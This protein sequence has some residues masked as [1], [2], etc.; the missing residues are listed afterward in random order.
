[1]SEESNDD[2]KWNSD[3]EFAKKANQYE[4][5][6]DYDFAIRA[7]IEVNRPLLIRGEPGIG[8]SS[9]A[10]AA[11]VKLGRYFI[12]EV[13]TAKTEPNDL[14]WQFDGVMRLGEATAICNMDRK[15]VAT[16][17]NRKN[18]TSPG[19]FWWAF[20]A[21]D[22]FKRYQQCSIGACPVTECRTA[23]EAQKENPGK[24]I[25]WVVLIDE[26]DKADSDIPN[27]LLGT[28][29][30][31]EFMVPGF[32]Q[33]ICQDATI[34]PPLIIITTNEDREL[35]PAFLRRCFVLHM[36]FPQD[37][38]QAIPWLKKCAQSHI[39]TAVSDD[40][41]EIMARMV[42]RARSDAQGCHKPGLAE[43][44]DLVC[45]YEKML[46]LEQKKPNGMDGDAILKRLESFTLDKNAHR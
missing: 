43:Y 37:E 42:L 4:W 29:A 24:K 20:Q 41:M 38:G 12:S 17:L 25:G 44:I 33:P 1:M 26:I 11:A 19:V 31:Q 39:K 30:N 2:F 21:D 6:D 22:A 5:D 23:I 7:A 13:I 40:D 15:D 10:R 46:A 27:S 35:P 8:K 32:E 18:Y 36:T 28:L 34:K 16:T 14:L 45:A 3:G 9:L